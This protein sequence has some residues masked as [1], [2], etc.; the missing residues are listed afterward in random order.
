MPSILIQSYRLFGV[1]FPMA[2]ALYRFSLPVK[3]Y[4]LKKIIHCLMDTI[5][6][7][8][9]NKAGEPSTVKTIARFISEGRLV[10][11][12][13]ATIYGI[14]CKYD[15]KNALERIH[16][17]KKRSTDMPF[18]ILISNPED[19]KI[20]TS[21]INAAARYII[22]KF[23]NIKKPESLTLIFNKRKNLKSFITSS[24]HTIAVRMAEPEFLRDI[25]DI[26]GPIVSTSATVSGVKTL[27]GSID[28]IPLTIKKNV[29]LIVECRSSLPGVESTIVSMEGD[30]PVLVR[31][32]KVNFKDVLGAVLEKNK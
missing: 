24:R 31:E 21:R 27:P 29:D 12:P 7:N 6:I 32:G 14:S 13:T 22:D 3:Y 8:N 11:L 18:I 20:F 5:K 19:L 23:W 1:M 16:R 15:D 17:I 28:E 9:L 26:C 2:A 30:C 10:I 4:I 25:I